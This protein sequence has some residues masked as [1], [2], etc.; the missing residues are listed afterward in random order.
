MEDTG[1]VIA[2]KHVGHRTL[3]IARRTL[4]ILL[5]EHQQGQ[6]IEGKVLS[7]GGLQVADRR[8]GEP[9]LVLFDIAE[10]IIGVGNVVGNAGQRA[11]IVFRGVVKRQQNLQGFVI[12]V[13]IHQFRG[14]TSAA[15]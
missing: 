1:V 8:R 10:Q 13:Q 15:A 3:D 4:H 5:L 12:T 7:D 14:H 11:A 2:G 6:V 9:V